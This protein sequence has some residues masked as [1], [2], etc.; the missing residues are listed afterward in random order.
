MAAPIA[1]MNG[2]LYT[3]GLALDDVYRAKVTA[4]GIDPNPN[5]GRDFYA[6]DLK[7]GDDDDLVESEIWWEDT[8]GMTAGANPFIVISNGEALGYVRMNKNFG[9]ATRAPVNASFTV[10]NIR[11]GGYS[12]QQ[13][14][15]AILQA[16][17]DHGLA[18]KAAPLTLTLN[19]T[20]YRHTIPAG[21]DTVY[22]FEYTDNAGNIVTMP[23]TMWRD[24]I[25]IYGRTVYLPYDVASFR[26]YGRTIWSE[27]TITDFNAVITKRPN[28]VVRAA[29]SWI[30]AGKLG[31]A[32]QASS[33]RNF[34]I[35]IRRIRSTLMP[36]EVVLSEG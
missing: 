31:R 15:D 10:G 6:D 33:Q 28:D 14:Y 23:P 34:D 18:I 1:S 11:A 4:I 27:P 16:F 22:G 7:R 35:N 20:T 5:V 19:T 13:K 2:L 3:L 30:R 32:E 25:N 8:T 9:V 21:I 12:H 29:L 36:N 26:A 17:A 24:Q